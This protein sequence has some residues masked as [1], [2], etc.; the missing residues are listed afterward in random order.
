MPEEKKHI[1]PSWDEYFMKMVD[2][3][4]ERGTCDRG[5]AGTVIVRDKRVVATG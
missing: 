2:F 5:R 1:R 4:G 3:V